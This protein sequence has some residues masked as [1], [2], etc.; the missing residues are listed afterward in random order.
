MYK[1]ILVPLDGSK[2]AEAVLP[3]VEH[4]GRSKDEKIVLL[5]IAE[6]PAILERDE[7]ADLTAHHKEYQKR[8][9]TAKAY[10]EEKKEVFRKKGFN[11][12]IKISSGP[13][14]SAILRVAEEVGADVIA[15]SS[16]GLG[17]SS[18]MFYG[19]TA[20]GILQRVDRPLLLIRTR[21]M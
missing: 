21:R 2:L 7:V 16:H 9:E 6:Q 10:L 19:S 13:V 14:V 4:I 5:T 18:R 12:E 1:T 8:I 15:M 20:A 3:H 11:V 17:G